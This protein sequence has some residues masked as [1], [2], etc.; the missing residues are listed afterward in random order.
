MKFTKLFTSQYF[1][2]KKPAIV[3]IEDLEESLVS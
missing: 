3:K 2:K 1:S